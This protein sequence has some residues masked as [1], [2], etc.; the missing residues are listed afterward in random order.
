M[1]KEQRQRKTSERNKSQFNV[2][3]NSCCAVIFFLPKFYDTLVYFVQP[4][5]VCFNYKKETNIRLLVSLMSSYRLRN[6]NVFPARWGLLNSLLVKRW[7]Y[8]S[9]SLWI[10]KELNKKKNLWKEVPTMGCFVISVFP[11]LQ[12]EIGRKQ[13]SMCIKPYTCKKKKKNSR[14]PPPNK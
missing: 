5:T 12:Q 2:Y 9:V 6:Q 7:Y 8:Y 13:L 11:T 3:L 10:T 14:F 4:L 1:L